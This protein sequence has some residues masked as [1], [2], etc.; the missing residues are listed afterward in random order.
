[1]PTIEIHMRPQGDVLSSYMDSRARVSC[2]MGPLGSG[3]TFQSCQKILTLMCE[4]RP[5]DSGIRKSRWYAIRNTYPDLTSTTIKD[6]LELFGELGRYKGGGME[7][8]THTLDFDLPD[9]TTVHSQLVF[10]ALDRED[11]VKKLRGAQVTGFWL[12]EMKELPKSIVD[13]ADLRHGRYP[14]AVD[15]GASWHGMIG[16]TNAPDEDHWYYRLAEEERPQ[17]WEFFRQPGGV[18]SAGEDGD[19]RIKW[20]PNP[21]AENINNLPDGYYLRGL[22]GKSDDWIGVNLANGYGFV[23]DGKPVHPHY[24]D[25]VHC[26]D[27]EILPDQN[28]PICVGIDFGRTPAAVILQKTAVGRW[29]ALDELVTEDMSAALFG[30]ELKRYLDQHYPGYHVEAWGDPAGSG[31]GQATDDTPIQILRAHGIP[32]QPCHSNDPT[33]RRAAIANPCTRLCMDGKPGLLISPKCRVLRKGLMGGF[34]YRRLRVAG[35][36]RYQEVPDKNRF[37][38]V[39]E[40]AE[41]GL[42]GGGEGHAAVRVKAPAVQV[43]SY[44]PSV[45]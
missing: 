12:N 41:Y 30:P 33:L 14:S 25:S 24:I 27:S 4:Q 36:E 44:R 21:L 17:G 13:M 2:I 16:D 22:A 3:K 29:V 6:W 35:D 7:P 42:L 11:A 26:A 5:N 28:V 19:G 9:G 15:G 31:R 23:Q 18:I 32:V 38:H 8:P 40:A 43:V 45:Y 20:Q 39:V 10:V 1:M 37:S 34:C